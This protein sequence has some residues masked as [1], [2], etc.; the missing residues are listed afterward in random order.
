MSVFSGCCSIGFIYSF[1]CFSLVVLKVESFLE[2][3]G[4]EFD[5][6]LVLDLKVVLVERIYLLFFE[7]VGI[8]G[9]EGFLI[10]VLV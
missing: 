7:E 8:F 1:G 6:F 4:V 3:E 10:V 5:V 9:I 2:W